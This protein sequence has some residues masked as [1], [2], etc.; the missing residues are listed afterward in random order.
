MDKK[1]NS[2]NG[3]SR[4][5]FIKIS[6]LS[7]AAFLVYPGII[8]STEKQEGALFM[9]QYLPVIEKCD[10]LIAG[11]GFAGC[12][13]IAASSEGACLFSRGAAD[14][15]RFEFAEHDQ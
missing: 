11:G 10:V 15:S 6:G 14:T 13:R 7:S 8:N 3:L 2:E 1:C 9:D 12:I 4:R 5:D